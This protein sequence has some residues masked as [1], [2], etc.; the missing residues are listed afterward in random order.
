MSAVA[1]RRSGDPAAGVHRPSTLSHVMGGPRPA[2]PFRFESASI[3][4]TVAGTQPIA[5]LPA[6]QL[7]GMGWRVKRAN[8]GGG[9]RGRLARYG[10]RSIRLGDKHATSHLILTIWGAILYQLD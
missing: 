10:K 9:C 1:T 8:D 5:P 7:D 2:E 4:A 6:L 3:G